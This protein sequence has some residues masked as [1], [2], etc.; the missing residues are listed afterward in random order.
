MSDFY[1]L[2]GYKLKNA[3]KISE[4]MEDYIEMIYRETI[5]TDK[6]TIKQISEKLNVKPSSV[7]KMANK[8]KLLNFINFERYGQISLT[9]EGIRL[10]KYLFYRHNILNDFFI[11]LNKEKYK[12][13]Q[14]EKIE[15]F[16]DYD[17]IIN[18]ENL[19]KKNRI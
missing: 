19:L 13:E 1:T 4:A 10:G 14:V 7:S 12:L 9:K 3:N 11:K 18:I 15:H 16:I 17:T 2:K 5:N 6:V 8:L